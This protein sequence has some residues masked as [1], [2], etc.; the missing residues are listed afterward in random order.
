[1]KTGILGLLQTDETSL[2]G[3]ITTAIEGRGYSYL[4]KGG[5]LLKIRRGR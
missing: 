4:R 1:M 2:F 3:T 5:D